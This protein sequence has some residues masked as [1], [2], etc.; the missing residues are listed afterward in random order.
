MKKLNKKL[1]EPVRSVKILVKLMLEL[2]ALK[3]AS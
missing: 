1:N 2:E 3:S